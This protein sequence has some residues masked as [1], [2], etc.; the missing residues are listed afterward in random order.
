MGT[1]VNATNTV[2]SGN[3]G[4]QVVT[5]PST[6]SGSTLVVCDIIS[7]V[8]TG[9]SASGASFTQRISTS[10]SGTYPNVWS[11]YNV[12]AG[13]TQVTVTYTGY[14]PFYGIIFEVGSVKTASDPWDTSN[15]MDNGY[16]TTNLGTGTITTGSEDG[17][18]IAWFPDQYSV[19]TGCT[20]GTGWT[21]GTFSNNQYYEYRSTTASTG[22]GG[23]NS[24]ATGAGSGIGFIGVIFNLL[25]VSA[26]GVSAYYFTA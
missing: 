24:Q 7:E 1:I 11:A 19:A 3:T 12:S 10:Y 17:I 21:A 13:I 15:S 26:S 14:R 22:Y 16:N 2:L 23:A 5:I 4:S 9:V 6:T 20:N 8:L 18:A 25:N